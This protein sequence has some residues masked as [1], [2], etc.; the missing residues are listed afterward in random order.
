MA[1]PRL[2]EPGIVHV[3]RRDADSIVETLIHVINRTADVSE[4]D[5]CWRITETN[6]DR[7]WYPKDS[8][9]GVVVRREEVSS[10]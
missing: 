9:L 10:E 5:D 1:K 2:V 8:L 6:G 4:C 3:Q 7:H